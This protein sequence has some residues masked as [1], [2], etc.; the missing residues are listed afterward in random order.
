MNKWTALIFFGAQG[1]GKSTQT[2][3]TAKRYHLA[4]FETGDQLRTIAR[5]GGELGKTIRGFQERGELVGDRII[6]KIIH[7]FLTTI[8]SN[9]FKGII[10]D[11]FPRNLGQCDILTSLVK[12]NLWNVEVVNITI[13]DKTALER[14]SKRTVIADGKTTT[15]ADDTPDIIA[16]RLAAFHRETE[17]VVAKLGQMYPVHQ[18]DGEPPV[19]KV[20][21]QIFSR[22]DQTL[23][24]V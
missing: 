3:A 7:K 22:L 6:E 12:D 15:R 24:V 8:E 5:E 20:A 11:G 1:S 17:P 14:L 19:E 16:K 18:I 21:E 9:D 2:Q 13:A 4:I 23:N 10:F